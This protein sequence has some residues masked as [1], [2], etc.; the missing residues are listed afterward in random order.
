MFCVSRRNV[1]MRVERSPL[2]TIYDALKMED[3]FR[4]FKAGTGLD[5]C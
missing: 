4:V 1:Q 5:V 2:W 3:P